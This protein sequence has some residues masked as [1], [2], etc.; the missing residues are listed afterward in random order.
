MSVRIGPRHI[1]DQ[2]GT[3]EPGTVVDYPSTALV[4]LANSGA[5]DPETGLAYCETVVPGR[6][7]GRASQVAPPE[8]TDPADTAEAEAPEVADA[9]E[10]TTT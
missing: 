5:K 4:E 8:D 3:Y 9:T 1:A 10:E 7:R 6:Q 2:T